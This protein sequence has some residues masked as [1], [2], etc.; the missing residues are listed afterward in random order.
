MAAAWAPARQVGDCSPPGQSRHRGC[1]SG[2]STRGAVLGCSSQVRRVTQKPE[3][4]RQTPDHETTRP[5]DHQTTRHQDLPGLVQRVHLPCISLHPLTPLAPSPQVSLKA[6]GEAAATKLELRSKRFAG[7]THALH[8]LCRSRPKRRYCVYVCVCVPGLTP[9]GAAACHRE[10]RGSCT[11]A[12]Q[13]SRGAGRLRGDCGEL[14]LA[15]AAH[16]YTWLRAVR[17]LSWCACTAGPKPAAQRLPI[18]R[19]SAPLQAAAAQRGRRRRHRHGHRH[20]SATGPPSGWAAAVT[21]HGGRTALKYLTDTHYQK[22]EGNC[23]STT[24]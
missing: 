18:L 4:R 12:A 10:S 22:R 1:V 2:P 19:H 6:E 17:V 15:T 23:N 13:E 16:R 14:R 20:V 8:D 5:P 24:P 7:F 9:G 3:T 11:R 21:S